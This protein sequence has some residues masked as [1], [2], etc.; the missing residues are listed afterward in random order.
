M[1]KETLGNILTVIGG[2]LLVIGFILAQVVGKGQYIFFF[3]GLALGLI[4]YVL[5]PKRRKR[6]L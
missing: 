5:R 3:A 1:E 2:A 6:K 4:G